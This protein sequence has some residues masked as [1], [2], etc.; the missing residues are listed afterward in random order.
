MQGTGYSTYIILCNSASGP[1]AIFQ[2]Q[3]T[4]I[5]DTFYVFI[6][7]AILEYNLQ[8]ANLLKAGHEKL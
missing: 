8:K 7:F 6:P 4:V 2:H 3:H 1:L 5:T